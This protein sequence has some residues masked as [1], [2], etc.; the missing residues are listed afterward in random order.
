M[1]FVSASNELG[2]FRAGLV[3]AWFGTVP[4]VLLGGASALAVVGLW[5]WLFPELRRIDRL[6]DVRPRAGD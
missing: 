2:D 3:A 6:A 4:A 5:A 1:L